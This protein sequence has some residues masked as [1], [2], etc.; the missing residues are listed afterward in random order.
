MNIE[1][2]IE[3]IVN[4]CINNYKYSGGDAKPKEY[5]IKKLTNLLTQQR[6]EAVRGFAKWC[7]LDQE[8]VFNHPHFMQE[9]AEQYLSQQREKQE[10]DK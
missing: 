5:F 1:E 6:E 2:Q 7:D 4:E 10:E 9:Y 8:A 3:E